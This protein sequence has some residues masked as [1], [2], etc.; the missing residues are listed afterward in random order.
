[1]MITFEVF[2]GPR[3]FFGQKIKTFEEIQKSDDI[4]DYTPKVNKSPASGEAGKY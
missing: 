2:F 1:M 4:Q 3:R